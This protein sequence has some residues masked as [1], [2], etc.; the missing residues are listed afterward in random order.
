M[1]HL[2]PFRC[3][4]LTLKTV[5][6]PIDY[7]PLTLIYLHVTVSLPEI[8]FVYGGVK[9]IQR[10]P[11]RTLTAVEKPIKPFRYIQISFLRLLQDVVISSGMLC[12]NAENIII[13]HRN[14]A[15]ISLTAP[16]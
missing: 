6:K 15:V 2:R 4:K 13:I 16:D 14:F 7:L 5:P 11:E 12:L 8:T 9:P 10:P 1:T 3:G